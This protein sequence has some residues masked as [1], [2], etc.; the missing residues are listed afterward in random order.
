VAASHVVSSLG[1][2]IRKACILVDLSRTACG[3]K[4]HREGDATLRNRLRE[5]RRAAEKVWQPQ[6]AYNAQ[7]RESGGEPQTD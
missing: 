1:P 4:S 3:Y 5:L 7:E 6:A 2:S